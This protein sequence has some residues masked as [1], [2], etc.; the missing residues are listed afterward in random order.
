MN[1]G[2]EA[3]VVVVWHGSFGAE[4]DRVGETESLEDGVI[5]MAP[6]V[7]KCARTIVQAFTPL[8]RVVVTLDELCIGSRPD[9]VVP[10]ES[11]GD[12][13]LSVGFWVGVP[14][15]LVAE[16]VSF[17]YLA[18]NSIVCLLYTSDAADE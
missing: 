5:D 18:Y 7:P 14:P 12:G 13:I 9:P 4:G 11:F 2:V 6:H 16:G 1:F 8:A 3:P 17:L 10:V 15:A